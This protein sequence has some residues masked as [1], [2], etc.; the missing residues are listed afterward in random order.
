[1]VGLLPSRVACSKLGR[2]MSIA[3]TQLRFRCR[4]LRFPKTR[5]SDFYVESI[6]R[7]ID[8]GGVHRTLGK[9]YWLKGAV[10]A[11]GREHA[12]QAF[13]R[14][15]SKRFAIIVSHGLAPHHSCVDY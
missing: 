13:G 7:K 15:G 1:M 11:A 6:I 5:F 2:A 8:S 10:D 3:A 12:L 14:A 9:N 4:R